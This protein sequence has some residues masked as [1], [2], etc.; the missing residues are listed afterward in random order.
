MN[1]S[2]LFLPLVISLGA[3]SLAL[4]AVLVFRGVERPQNA[5]PSQAAGTTTDPSKCQGN[6]NPSARC[7]DCHKDA[8]DKS[9]VNTLDFSCFA[10]FYG[11][12]VGK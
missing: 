10:K 2:P 3:I 9:Q 5:T 7:F 11:K 1:R 4:L 8:T 12:S 6:A